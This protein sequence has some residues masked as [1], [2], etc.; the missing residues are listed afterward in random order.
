MGTW[1]TE[2]YG[3]DTT[4]DVRDTYVDYLRKNIDD[5]EAYNVTYS[6]YSELMGTEEESLFWF[7]MADTQWELGRLLPIVKYN[8]IKF[9]NERCEDLFDEL[10]DSEMTNW[11]NMLHTLLM[12]LDAP[13]PPKKDVSLSQRFERNPWEIGDIYAYKFHSKK[14]KKFN[15][16]GKYIAIQKIGESLAYDDLTFSV[17]QI[18]N[19]VFS[20]CPTISD[21]AN[22]GVLPL[23]FPPNVEGTPKSIDDYIPSFDWYSKAI[24]LLDKPS[25]FPQ[26]NFIFVGH[27][28]IQYKEYLGNECSNMYWGSTS[29]EEWIIDYYISWYNQTADI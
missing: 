27:S 28:P 10:N 25:D 20:S 6:K 22:L 8:A 14:S 12:K 15:L 7:A 9:I 26:K 16:Y 5:V 23:V 4:A 2:L 11:D 19:K 18:Y 17:V 24:M 1:S 3:N 13:M 21:I 29:M